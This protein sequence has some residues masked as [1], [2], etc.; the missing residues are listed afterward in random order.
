MA[1]IEIRVD[2]TGNPKTG[3]RFE[4]LNPD[5]Q[6]ASHLKI[7]RKDTTCWISR[8][9]DVLIDF[10]AGPNPFRLAGPYSAPEGI[11]TPSQHISN[12]AVP[13]SYK[14]YATA[15]KNDC[16]AKLELILID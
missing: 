2:A 14:Y 12:Q 13:G 7:S 10:G 4:V 3:C 11:P 8:T 9:G 15:N 1:N 6:D 5:S 16:T